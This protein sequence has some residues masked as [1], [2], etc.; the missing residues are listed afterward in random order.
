MGIAQLSA[1]DILLEKGLVPQQLLQV[2][3]MANALRPVVAQHD[4]HTPAEQHQLGKVV[5]PDVVTRVQ[6]VALIPAQH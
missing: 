2:A 1:I 5:L 4:V 3:V 6:R